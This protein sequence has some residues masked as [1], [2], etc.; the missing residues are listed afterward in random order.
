MWMYESERERERD[1]SLIHSTNMCEELTPL[2]YLPAPIAAR[3]RPVCK[4]LTL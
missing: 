3:L 4:D 2:V 1:Q